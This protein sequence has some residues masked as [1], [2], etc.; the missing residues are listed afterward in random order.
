[1]PIVNL[2]NNGKGP[3]VV[4]VSGG[5][6]VLIERGQTRENIDMRE[7]DIEALAGGPVTAIMAAANPVKE[8]ALRDDDSRDDLKAQADELG[9]EYPKN[10]PTEKL[11]ELIDAS[12]SE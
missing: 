1:M 8:P 3:R 9:I 7:A 2:T 12:L 6:N 4:P 5:G 10:I 11:K